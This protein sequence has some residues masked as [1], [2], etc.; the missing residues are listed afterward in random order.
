MKPFPAPRLL[1]KRESASDRVRLKP[2]VRRLRSPEQRQQAARPLSSLPAS[3]ALERRGSPESFWGSAWS[4]L[5]LS[6][7]DPVAPPDTFNR[8]LGYR[9]FRDLTLL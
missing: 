5:P 1:D 9:P 6:H 3:G 2:A 4:L 7:R 8:S